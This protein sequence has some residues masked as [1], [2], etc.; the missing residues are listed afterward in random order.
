MVNLKTALCAA[1]G[2]VLAA[3]LAWPA[4]AT[5]F[6]TLDPAYAQQIY[7]GPFVGGPGMAWTS[8]GNFLTRD[9]SNIL[10]YDPLASATYLGTTIHPVIT[11]HNIAG[12]LTGGYGITNGLDGYIY[13]N[14]G[15]GVQKVD[16][17]T[18]TVTTPGANLPNIPGTIG[19]GGGYGITTLP[20]GKIAYVA[21]SGTNEV[22]VYDPSAATNLLIYS[23]GTLIDDI[24]A[25][26]SGEIALAGYGNNSIIMISGAGALL[27]AT[28]TV[29]HPDGLAFGYG[30]A[31]AVL[32]SND[33]MGTI[34][35]YDFTG[36]YSV[37][38]TISIIAS[39]G[40]YGDLAAVGPDCA[41]YAFQGF[42]GQLNGSANFGTHWGDTP[43]TTVTN[44][45][46]SIVRIASSRPGVC[47]FA[48]TGQVPEPGTLP[49]LAF[50]LL[51]PM[52]WSRQRKQQP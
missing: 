9:Q 31:V 28:P 13:V 29:Q 1:L 39:G 22:Y 41:L 42:N 47:A 26:P 5:Q 49:L 33:N 34:S 12:L 30:A 40:S 36:G 27:S 14:T 37:A 8:S 4:H 38:P 24:Q 48:P 19:T 35:K 25:S 10:E 23:A 16:P 11:T 21:G 51:V 45:Q 52:L 50:G 2:S 15:N 7:T 6:S 32:F 17:T 3:T 46:S 44:N 18:W 20:N 43:N